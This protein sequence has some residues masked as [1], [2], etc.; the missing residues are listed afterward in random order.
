MLMVGLS[1]KKRT[2]SYLMKTF[3]LNNIFLYSINY[4]SWLKLPFVG[5]ATVGFIGFIG[6]I[7]PPA[8]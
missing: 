1:K 4:A 5:G 8:K 2:L 7:F 3:N 6:F